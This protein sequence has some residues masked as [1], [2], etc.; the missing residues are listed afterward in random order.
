MRE[1]G[2]M[3]TRLFTILNAKCIQSCRKNAQVDTKM[4][5]TPSTLPLQHPSHTDTH[6]CTHSHEQAD[7]L[8]PKHLSLIHI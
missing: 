5:R 1:A 4:R 3:P 8:T 2:K 6:T 7:A